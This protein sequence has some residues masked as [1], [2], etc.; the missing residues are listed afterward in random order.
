M[1]DEMI[2]NGAEGLSPKERENNVYRF[3]DSLGISYTRVEHEAAATIADCAEVDK[4]LGCE[5]CKN[6]FLCNRQKTVF[7]LLLMRGGKAFVTKDISQQLGVSRLSFGDAECME[8]YLGIRPGAVSLMGLIND[9]EH[10]VR[11]LIDEDM[12]QDEFL[13]CHPCVNTA[14]LKIA[15]KEITEKFLPAVGHEITWV[16]MDGKSAEEG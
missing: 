2:P 3:L 7:Y 5:M 10:N 14:S 12:K 16:H 1:N 11:L 4:M 15:W 9:R 6:L 8:K 13:G